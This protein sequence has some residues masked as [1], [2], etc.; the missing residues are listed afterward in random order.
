MKRLKL[1]QRQTNQ[2]SKESVQMNPMLEGP[3]VPR[4]R[5]LITIVITIQSSR[6][7]SKSGNKIHER[8]QQYPGLH[9]FKYLIRSRFEYN[10]TVVQVSV[11]AL[12][13]QPDSCR[14]CNLGYRL[15]HRPV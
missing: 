11:K 7:D 13:M 1:L 10:G 6:N 15:T 4:N 14:R 2:E 3:S 12:Q 9:L 5:T 8:K